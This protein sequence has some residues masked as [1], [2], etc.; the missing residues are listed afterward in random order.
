VADAETNLAIIRRHFDALNRGDVDA[1]G[2]IYAEDCTNHGRPAGRER[3]EAILRDILTTFPDHKFELL[4]AVGVGDD[5]VIR[6]VSSGTHLGVSRLPIMGALLM[7]V[8]PTEKSYAAQN[9]H[10]FRMKGGQV[11]DHRASRDDLGMLQQ[12]GIVPGLEARPESDIRRP[13][14]E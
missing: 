1:A 13:L 8:A 9:I 12:L 14:A 3:I 2:A 5:V 11:Q 4:D 10:W 6:T 7:G